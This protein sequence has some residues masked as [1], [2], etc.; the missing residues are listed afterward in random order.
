M[1]FTTKP[2]LVASLVL[3]SG[4]AAAPMLTGSVLQGTG[5]QNL[6]PNGAARQ[7]GTTQAPEVVG[8]DSDMP[9]ILQELGQ[10][11]KVS[12]DSAMSDDVD[13]DDAALAW[14][15]RGRI[16]QLSGDSARSTT[17]FKQAVTKIKEFEDR[18]KISASDVGSHA[19]A[20]VVN[21]TMIPYEPA[22]FEKVMVYHLQA[23][24]YLMQGDVEAAG[25]ELR[26][27]NA[28]QALALKAHEQELLEAQKEAQQKGFKPSDFTASLNQVLGSSKDVAAQV[29]NSFQNAYTFYA[30]AVIRELSGEANDAYIDYKKALE[31][32]PHN[33]I[34]QRDV[35]RLAQ[36]LGMGDDIAKFS[37][38]F[39]K[40]F[41]ATKGKPSADSEVIVFFEDGLVPEKTAIS[42]PIP[43][44]IPSAPGLTAV[45]IP[46]F[47]ASKASSNPLTLKVN[48]SPAAQSEQICA[49][50]ALAVKAYEESAPAMITR[51][52][53]RSAIKGTAA[54][55]ASKHGGGLAGAAVSLYNT[56]TEQ[57]DTRSWRS[58]PNN[59]Q[60]LRTSVKP[61]QSLELVH[62]ATGL[63][64]SVFLTSEPGKKTVVRA[65]R[66]GSQLFVQSV[67]L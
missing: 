60:G 37:A 39:P 11:R 13:G 45:S 62:P 51:Q 30:S 18:A 10:G 23:L 35:A 16:A 54:A 44:P 3:T 43:I 47:K 59:A 4:C 19:A 27:A 6:M 2:A 50:D 15:E 65:T 34:I 48:G 20:L 31:I 14:I 21:D 41:A 64:Q 67:T 66:V 55:M 38:R 56:L 32:A 36:Q 63:R 40:A 57:A 17:E 25:V 8:V 22:G 53:V 42:F 58:L 5:L 28:E 33:S 52:V 1:K 61:G 49:I 24:N 9:E 12:V 46:T 7:G 26:R 29:K